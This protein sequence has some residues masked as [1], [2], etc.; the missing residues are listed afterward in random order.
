MDYGVD[1]YILNKRVLQRETKPKFCFH[2]D[3]IYPTI[4]RMSVDVFVHNST[5]Q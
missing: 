5:N 4:L 1:S 3:T 2:P